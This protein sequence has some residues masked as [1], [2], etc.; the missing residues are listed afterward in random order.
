MQVSTNFKILFSWKKNRF[1]KI[2]D[3]GVSIF[4]WTRLIMWK[5][6]MLQ[7]ELETDRVP[8]KY[9]NFF[10]KASG[11]KKNVARRITVWMVSIGC[12]HG[13]DSHFHWTNHVFYAQRRLS[14]H[15]V[16]CCRDDGYS[17]RSAYYSRSHLH[18][19]ECV[20]ATHNLLGLLRSVTEM[21]KRNREKSEGI[22][23]K[24]DETIQ[25]KRCVGCDTI[26]IG[27]GQCTW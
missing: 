7:I 3:V 23:R 16:R 10:N 15:F 8:R 19:F 24:I 20:V 18:A 4:Q 9:S 22:K 17:K 1:S 12:H 2:I 26:C 6:D 21:M 14:T 13:Y 27:C 5:F 11:Y 25:F